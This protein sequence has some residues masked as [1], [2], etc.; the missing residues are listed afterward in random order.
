MI[1]LCLGIS[2]EAPSRIKKRTTKKKDIFLN[3]DH[4]FSGLFFLK[5]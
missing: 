5:D 4:F 3:L 2:T 1:A